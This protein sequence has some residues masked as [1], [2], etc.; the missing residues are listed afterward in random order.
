[1]KKILIAGAFAVLALA[2]CGTATAD[3]EGGS[4]KEPDAMRDATSVTVYRNAD[5]VPNVALF[6][7]GKLR[8]ASTLSGSDAG[9]NKAATIIRIPEQDVECGGLPQ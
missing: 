6:C 8:F 9:E 1:M 3:R 7:V 5:S 2:G 4:G